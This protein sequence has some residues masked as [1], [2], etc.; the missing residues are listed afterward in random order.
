MTGPGDDA[1]GHRKPDG[2]PNRRVDGAEHPWKS[3]DDRHVWGG[4]PDRPPAER[5]PQEP[6]PERVRAPESQPPGEQPAERPQPE[7]R[8]P[9][10]AS[11]PPTERTQAR[12]VSSHRRG[13]RVG[14]SPRSR[15]RRGRTRVTGLLGPSAEPEWDPVQRSFAGEVDLY[16]IATWEP[17][18]ALDSFA[19]S[20]TGALRTGRTL[21][22]VGI[23]V[24][25]FLLQGALALLTVVQEPLVG[26]LAVSSILPAL[27]VAG[28]LWYGDPTRREPF[29]AL[30]A[31]FLLSVLFAGFAGVVNSALG[32]LF[33]PL[34]AVGVV[35]LYF[36]VV[37]PVEESVKWL[38]IRVYAYR[39]NAFQTVVDGV[40]YGAAAGVGFA[41][42][43][44]LLYIGTVYLEAVET[45]GLA[46]TE[47]ATSV[48]TQRFFVGPGHVVFSAWAGFYLGLARFNPENRGP[49]V[50]KGL[51]IAVFIHA[52]YNTSVTVLPEILPGIPLLGFILVYHGFWFTL[53][54]RK[55]RSYREL[56]RAQSAERRPA[57]GPDGPGTPR[58]T[59]VRNERRR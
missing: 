7:S 36:L 35:G 3:G 42:I 4:L 53:L 38:A 11:R 15:L 1:T 43:E 29:A 5:P 14:R 22:L 16:D 49:I 39:N 25:L 54:Y 50:V 23:A 24:L 56:Y 10:Q 2:E 44:N 33:E 26:V 58:G 20:V 55:I 13:G 59:G 57:G 37:G 19:V 40:V 21:L 47:A 17:R 34:G 12:A 18:T 9:V 46:P 32:P 31:T 45:P 27:L 41:A 6:P 51:L 8:P 30:G 28:Y 52:M 48:A